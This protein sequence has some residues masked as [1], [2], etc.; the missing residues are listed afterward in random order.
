MI[1]TFYYLAEL[2]GSLHGPNF[3]IRTSEVYRS[4]IKFDELLFQFIAKN[5]VFFEGKS[6]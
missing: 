5:K 6:F 2:I 3:A 1:V 4:Q